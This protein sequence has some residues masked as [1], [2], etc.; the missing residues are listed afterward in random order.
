MDRCSAEYYLQN[1]LLKNSE[2]IK[3]CKKAENLADSYDGYRFSKIQGLIGSLNVRFLS[4]PRIP[5]PF[6]ELIRLAGNLSFKRKPC[7]V[8]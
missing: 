7:P 3:G 8:E 6:I 5:L 1:Q 2:D 4:V